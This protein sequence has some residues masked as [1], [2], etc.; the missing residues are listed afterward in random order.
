MRH[1]RVRRRSVCKFCVKVNREYRKLRCESSVS[2]V[3][4]SPVEIPA[5][6]PRPQPI[7]FQAVADDYRGLQFNGSSICIG[8]WL[9]F[10]PYLPYADRAFVGRGVTTYT[11]DTVRTTSYQG[12]VISFF[13][14]YLSFPHI[15]FAAL[16]R[17]CGTSAGRI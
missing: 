16:L 15:F 12:T 11:C 7:P 1:N 9:F 10:I 6:L 17:G 2:V 8:E 5:F 14:I 13:N 4:Q 3:H